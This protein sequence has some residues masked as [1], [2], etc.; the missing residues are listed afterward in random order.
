[1]DTLLDEK[2]YRKQIITEVMSMINDAVNPN[3]FYKGVD[4]QDILLDV[5]KKMVNGEVE[6]VEFRCDADLK[7]YTDS[8]LFSS[9]I[10]IATGTYRCGD[11]ELIIDLKVCGENMII[12]K[13]CMYNDVSQFPEDLVELIKTGPRWW[14]DNPDVEMRNLNRFEYIFDDDGR[15]Y[16]EDLSKATPE[17]LR[18]EMYKIA[19]YFFH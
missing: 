15:I 9:G 13:G 12:Y 5:E 1:M 2:I 19:K 16:E 11:L 3:A 17:E 18:D 10:T 6:Q 14:E 7:Q 4:I 8:I